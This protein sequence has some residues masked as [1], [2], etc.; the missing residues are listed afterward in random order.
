MD[1]SLA[2]LIFTLRP[3]ARAPLR[4]DAAV[5]GPARARALDGDVAALD[6]GAEAFFSRHI[7]LSEA[8]SRLYQRRFLQPNSHFAA[9]FKIYKIFI[10]LRRLNLKNCKISQKIS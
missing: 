9:F 2:H 1:R 7:T 8:R 4:R 5:L 10:I 3:G 6:G